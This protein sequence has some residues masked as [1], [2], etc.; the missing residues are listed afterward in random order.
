MAYDFIP[1]SALDISKEK[2]FKSLEYSKVYTYLVQKYK[3]KDPIALSKDAKEIKVVKI[4][5]SLQ[6]VL[7]IKQL[8]SQLNLKDIK[9]SFGE[10]SRGGR[11]V[12]NKGGQFEIDLTQ[13]L[14]TWWEGGK[15]GRAHV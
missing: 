1:N 5:R 4:T 7:D 12:K 13:D 15:I 8:H 6:S 14:I 2:V 10:G 3:K 9:L 11:G